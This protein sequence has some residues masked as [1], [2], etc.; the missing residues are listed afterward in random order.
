LVGEPVTEWPFYS[1]VSLYLVP[2]TT[3][4]IERD[5]NAIATASVLEIPYHTNDDGSMFAELTV[6]VNP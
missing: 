2:S 1:G 4:T 6:A 5:G 3:V